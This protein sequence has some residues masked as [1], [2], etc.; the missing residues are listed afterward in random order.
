M[1][2]LHN[3]WTL[4][5]QHPAQPTPPHPLIISCF[6][7]SRLWALSMLIPGNKGENVPVA[8]WHV[9]IDMYPITPT[10]FIVKNIIRFCQTGG[11]SVLWSCCVDY[12]VNEKPTLNKLNKHLC[13]VLLFLFQKTLISADNLTIKLFGGCTKAKSGAAMA[14]ARLDAILDLTLRKVNA[15]EL[16]WIS[17]SAECIFTKESRTRLL[18]IW[19]VQI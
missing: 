4:T 13:T 7:H 8:Y 14:A 12:F 9:Q 1:H 16:E 10:Q 6:P 17:G 5:V 15:C 2:A 11:I 18:T 19:T 3:V